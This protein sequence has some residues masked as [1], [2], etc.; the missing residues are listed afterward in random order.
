MRVL[1]LVTLMVMLAACATPAAAP[2]VTTA[3]LAATTREQVTTN[4]PRP[5]ETRAA[6]TR[7]AET[8]AAESTATIATAATSVPLPTE[9]RAAESTP[10]NSP[11]PTA[12]AGA[13]NK[14]ALTYVPGSS[15]KLEQLLGDCDWT[16]LPYGTQGTCH[17]PT[18]SQTI[19][20]YNILGTDEGYSFEYNG[21]LV[22]LFGDTLPAKGNF[23][24]LDTFAWSTST[25]PEA[26]LLLNFF[27]RK[28]GSP[29][30]VEPPK[31]SMGPDDVP[32]SGITLNN[33]AYFVVNTGSDMSQNDPHANDYSLLVRFDEAAGTFAAGRTIS[34][35]PGGHFIFTSLHLSG[36]DVLMFGTGDYRAGD[37]YL[38]TVPAGSFESGTGTRYFAGLSN[39]QPTWTNAESSAAPV[40]QD[41]LP[42]VGKVS[43]TYSNDLALWLMTYEVGKQTEDT[44]GV[45][46]TYAPA[47]WGPWSKS[48]LI[49]NDKRDH[50]NGVFIH[51]SSYNP[52]GPAGPMIGSA[53][54]PQTARGDVYAPFMIERF[55]R[56][57]GNSLK[58][59]YALST[60]NPYTVVK[61]RSELTI[62]R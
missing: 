16:D 43:V 15:V 12:A 17:K 51:D 40:V 5:G 27:Q 62:S 21:K 1:V 45:Y 13:A 58:I 14:P 35:L 8:R 54:D 57:T 30:F 33:Q 19:S 39:G 48:Q 61:M 28:D 2:T 46:F 3:P 10:T 41:S 22:F 53:N 59:Y 47:P 37:I 20:K 32:N 60:W 29:L 34:K 24:A 25:D 18:A 38:A 23:H 36:T 50:G 26:P 6:E 7:A 42:T 9:T 31:I 52:P 55:L 4:Q 11:V 56:V 44:R 49:F